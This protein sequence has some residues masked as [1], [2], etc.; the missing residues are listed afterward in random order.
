[1]YIK[2]E[3]ELMSVLNVCVDDVITFED[4][5]DFEIRE[6]NPIGVLP[7]DLYEIIIL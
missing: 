3:P 1:M 5:H 4:P 7:E 6:E 2:G